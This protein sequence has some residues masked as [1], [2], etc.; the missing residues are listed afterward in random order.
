MEIFTGELVN[1]TPLNS[2][3]RALAVNAEWLSSSFMVV[4][5]FSTVVRKAGLLTVTSRKTCVEDPLLAL[6]VVVTADE[7]QPA[8]LT[9]F[10][11]FPR[12]CGCNWQWNR[13]LRDL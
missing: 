10:V 12:D 11:V 13:G 4:V 7:N 8:C 3:P 2:P 9:F 5:L 6:V 1:V